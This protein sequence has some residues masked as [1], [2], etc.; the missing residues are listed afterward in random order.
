[1]TKV[2]IVPIPTPIE[3]Q[4]LAQ[5]EP[6][7]EDPLPPNSTQKVAAISTNDQNSKPQIQLDQD[8]ENGPKRNRS[9]TDLIC[10]IIFIIFIAFWIVTLF[11]AWTKGNVNS[12]QTPWDED[13]NQ[14]GVTEGYQ[15]YPYIYFYKLI[16]ATSFASGDFYKKTFCVGACPTYTIDPDIADLSTFGALNILCHD[17]T[18]STLA[19][20]CSA[21]LAYKS[22]LL[23]NNYCYPELDWVSSAGSSFSKA[24]SSLSS[25]LGAI[26]SLQEAANDIATAWP[27]I[28]LSFFLALFIGIL[29]TYL[30]R[31]FVGVITW[32]FILLAIAGGYFGGA[33]LQNEGL[34]LNDEI[35]KF[36]TIDSSA[37]VK[38][39]QTQRNW[40]YFFASLVFLF[41]TVILF[42]LMCNYHKIRQ[43]IQVIKTSARFVADNYIVMLCP[44]FLNL[45]VLVCQVLWVSGCACLYSIGTLTKNS[46]GYPWP[47]VEW[48]EYTAIS[49]W[50]NQFVIIWVVSFILAVNTFV[51]TAACCVWYFQQGVEDCA[52]RKESY[53]DKND[54]ES[55]PI[56]DA[57]PKPNDQ[58]SQVQKTYDNFK[59][60]PC[61]QGLKWAF[62][63]N[64]GSI[65]LGSSILSVIWVFQILF[66][67]AKTKLKQ[68]TGD[69]GNI[70]IKACL[71]CTTCCVSCFER[72]IEFL[73]QQ[74]YIQIALTGKS[75]C[76]SAKDA[77]VAI[78]NHPVE[79]QQMATIG[80]ASI[81]IGLLV[82][83]SA[84]EVICW[85]IF[86]KTDKYKNGLSSL[87]FPMFCC[88]LVAISIGKML[89]NIYLMGS[90]AVLICFFQDVDLQKNSGKPPRNTPNE[91]RS[92]VEDAGKK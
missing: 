90:Y 19:G 78:V 37:D 31:C 76:P 42:V 80:T 4:P 12:L 29:Y 69:K 56:V 39:L 24:Y 64:M 26:D 71:C 49:W 79:F 63:S 66:G 68:N 15:L 91:L 74:A 13:G 36:Q 23:L 33:L 34:D 25:S 55:K 32:Q 44:Q 9:C 21:Q 5:P 75:F 59:R 88:G 48:S 17:T 7:P 8:L 70:F 67:Y 47:S 22:Q 85:L 83:F 18:S 77:F 27:I 51:I 60:S 52:N 20:G 89:C 2:E 58:K 28:L 53:I 14:C 16:D 86:T 43:C 41:A 61:C 65:A 73:N 38:S 40:Y 81:Y 3:P 45:I 35:N 50:Y 30:L 62:W 82:I 1:M 92:F 46:D 54:E 87:W 11:Y 10:A 6:T 84:T 72:C 57:K